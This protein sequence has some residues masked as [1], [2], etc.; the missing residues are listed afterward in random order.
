MAAAER[1]QTVRRLTTRSAEQRWWWWPL[2]IALMAGVLLVFACGSGEASSAPSASPGPS[3]SSSAP[4]ITVEPSEASA[5]RF[6]TEVVGKLEQEA[7]YATGPG[8]LGPYVASGARD[9]V[10]G[11]LNSRAQAVR[12]A[13]ATFPGPTKRTWFTTAPLTVK[14]IAFDAPAGTAEVEVW[15][16]AVFSREDLGSPE[17]RFS[18]H[19]A[20]LAWDRTA[21]AWQ[22]TKLTALPGPAAALA[23]E[24]SPSAP[25]ELDSALTGHQLIPASSGTG[26]R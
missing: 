16:V 21:R 17:T 19:Q 6:G 26:G 7:L 23:S 12:W 3:A 24:Q 5:A 13:I 2:V 8:F 9:Q 22:I 11:E 4:A 15:V 18:R 10:A 14:V 25:A 1:Q 20:E